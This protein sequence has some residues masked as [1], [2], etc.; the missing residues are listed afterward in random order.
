LAIW[1]SVLLGVAGEAALTVFP[2]N[3]AQGLPTWLIPLYVC[4]AIASGLLALIL[5][6]LDRKLGETRAAQVSE[7]DVDLNEIERL[8]KTDEGVTKG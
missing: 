2:L 3:W 7:L 8:F 1:Y 5:V 4:V 6:L